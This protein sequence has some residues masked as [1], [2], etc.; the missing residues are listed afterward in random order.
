MEIIITLKTTKTMGKGV[1]N[2]GSKKTLPQ[3]IQEA[4]DTHNESRDEEITFKSMQFK[5][6]DEE[7]AAIEERI[8]SGKLIPLNEW[9]RQ[10][11]TAEYKMTVEEAEAHLPADVEWPEEVFEAGTAREQAIDYMR[12]MPD[13]FAINHLKFS[14]GTWFTD[15]AWE[16]QI[17]DGNSTSPGGEA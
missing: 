3:L 5:R 12:R 9:F 17:E 14:I 16:S 4:L 1:V 2:D 6:T 8:D 7:E 15:D 11:K 13:E 10:L